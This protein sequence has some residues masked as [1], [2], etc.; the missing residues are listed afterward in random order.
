MNRRVLGLLCLLALVLRVA[1]AVNTRVINHDGARFT[2]SARAF[3][4]GD[5]DAAL[6][7]EPRMPPL[8]PLLIV[9]LWRLTGDLGLAGVIISVLCGTLLV[10]PIY[11]L[12]RAMF[13]DRVAWLAGLVVAILPELVLVSGDVW[14]EP[15]FLLCFFSSIAAIWFAGERPSLRLHAL[16]GLF[17]G[18]AVN[19]RP[20]G[21]YTLAAILGWGAIVAWMHCRDPE[22]RAVRITG[23]LL[24]AAIWIALI[25]P[26]SN[27]I[28]SRFGFWSPTANQFAVQMLGKPNV[29]RSYTEGYRVDATHDFE[30]GRDQE[31]FGKVGGHLWYVI[32]IYLRS[33]GYV[34]LALLA[35]GL[36]FVRGRGAVFLILIAV[37][38]AIPTW[39]GLAVGLP[40]DDRFALAS[41]VALAPVIAVGMSRLWDRIPE[42]WPKAKIATVATAVLVIGCAVRPFTPRDSR[43]L[44]LAD[45]GRWIKEKHGPGQRILTMD[46][47]VE[48][49]ADAWSDRVPAAFGDLVSVVWEQKPVA[50]VMYDPYVDRHEAKFERRLRGWWKLIHTIPKGPRGHEVRIYER[51]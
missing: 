36:F 15:L 32:K 40:F 42:R 44:T 17:G 43:R 16:A 50:I 8:Y 30:S 29:E 47:R 23:P 3:L 48:H 18:L 33:S 46:R 38:Y 5:G 31:A 34:F 21:L 45:A 26:Y 20:E 24:A 13:G 11:L 28:H 9:Q 10:V 22:R 19:T 4:A 12:A 41:F 6:N 25:F 2:M 1:A 7:V 27:W 14:T 35:A 39:I 37:G 51:R 49:Y